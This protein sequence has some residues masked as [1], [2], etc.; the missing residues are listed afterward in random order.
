MND[1]NNKTNIPLGLNM[2]DFMPGGANS[3]GGESAGQQ[4][5]QPAEKVPESK[6]P[7]IIDDIY[8][9]APNFKLLISTRIKNL[10]NVSDIWDNAKNKIDTFEYLNNSKDLGII[11]DVV[12][13]S[14]IKTELKFMDMRSKEIAIIF[15]SVIAMCSSKYDMY[16]KNGILAAWKILQYLGNVIVS[17]KQSQLLNP[18]AIDIAKEDKIRV[19]DTIINYFQQLMGLD[20]LQSHLV[21]RPIE[22][23]DLQRFLSELNYFFKKCRGG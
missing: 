15:P 9:M 5:K 23:L 2:N 3:G 12:N 7:P 17:A 14:F 11:N 1:P 4:Y 8:K 16:F 19:Y 10:S 20:N 21:G 18:G 22:G 6:D 13:F